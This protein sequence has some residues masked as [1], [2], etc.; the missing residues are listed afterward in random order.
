MLER[1]AF[2]LGFALS[3]FLASA[4]VASAEFNPSRDEK[5]IGTFVV[6]L[7]VMLFLG[8]IYAVKW[9][10]GLEHAPE[11]VDMPEHGHH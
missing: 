10:F 7:G 5:V 11:E 6:A 9:Y 2:S 8:L 4:A 3:A 1:L